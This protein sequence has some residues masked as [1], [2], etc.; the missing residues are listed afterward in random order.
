MKQKPSN[1]NVNTTTD[2][3]RVCCHATQNDKLL[4]DFLQSK[5]IFKKREI[6]VMINFNT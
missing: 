6:K 2:M 4:G 3:K 1:L 5:G